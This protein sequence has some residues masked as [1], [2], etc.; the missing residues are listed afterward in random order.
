M[1][2]GW[3]LVRKILTRKYFGL[4]WAEGLGNSLKLEPMYYQL[5]IYL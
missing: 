5:F 3:V 4:M 2:Q 1:G